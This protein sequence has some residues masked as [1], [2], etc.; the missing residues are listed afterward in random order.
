MTDRPIYTLGYGARTIEELI[1]VLAQHD[2][3]YLIDVRSQPYSRFKPEYNREALEASLKAQ[4]I[5]YVFMGDSLGGRPADPACYT[6]DGKVDYEAYR[7]QPL[8]REGIER[9]RQAWEQQLSVAILCSEGRPENCHRSKLIGVTL[10]QEDIAVAHIDE[11]DRLLNQEE[12]WNRIIG[13]QPSLFGHDFARLTSRKRYRGDLP[14][15]ED[16]E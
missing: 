8:Y 4:G 13:G 12:V 15:D 14:G 11:N 10:A 16:E 9:L 5:R 3:A 6:D 1:D 7:L 2:I